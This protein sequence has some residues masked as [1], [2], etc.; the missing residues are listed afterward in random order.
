MPF[1][2]QLQNL[3]IEPNEYLFIAKKATENT[4]LDPK[5]LRFSSK[6][7]KKLEYDNIDFG[8]Y[9]Y[10]DFIIYTIQEK[11]GEI[12]KGTAKQMRDRYQKSHKAIKGD[13]KNKLSPNY[14]SLNINW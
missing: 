5:K 11:R 9:G 2:R 1:I 14:L 10:N 12:P 4:G 8:A 13:W 6:H 3:N 7:N